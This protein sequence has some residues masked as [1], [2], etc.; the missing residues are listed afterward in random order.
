MLGAAAPAEIVRRG[1][2][3]GLAA[4]LDLRPDSARQAE[5]K[6]LTEN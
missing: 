4:A 2:A 6:Q 1:R 3:A 5:L